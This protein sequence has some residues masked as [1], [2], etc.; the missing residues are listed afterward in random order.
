M[1]QTDILLNS[2]RPLKELTP[3]L[4]KLS[5]IME[6]EGTLPNLF[7]E[8]SIILMPELDK[9]TKATTTQCQ[10]NHSPIFCM[11]R[12]IKIVNKILTNHISNKLKRSYTMIKLVSFQG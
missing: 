10:T 1:N 5:H 11:N 6:R 7:Y 4:I 9:H 2:I 3:M 8:S 12:G